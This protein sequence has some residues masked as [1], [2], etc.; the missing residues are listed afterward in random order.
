MSHPDRVASTTGRLARVGFTDADAAAGRLVALEL[1]DH[2]GVVEE[3]GQVADPD[4]A[5]IALERIAAAG[6]R[7]ELL[8]MVSAHD[9]FRRRLLA[10]LGASAALGDWLVRHPQ[11]WRQ[12][13]DDDAAAARPT[14]FGLQAA[15]KREVDGRT[16]REAYDALRVGYRKALLGLAARDLCADLAVDN[17]AAELADLAEATL[18]AALRIAEREH[19]SGDSRLAV[20]AMGKCG[21]RELNYVSD[22]DVVFVA[23][24]ADAAPVATT[25]AAAMMRVCSET[26]SEGTI[27][28]VDAALRP[29][30]KSG[31]LVRTLA[32]HVGYYER[33]ASTWEFQALLKARAVAG[34]STLGAEYV[35]AVAP[36]VWDA[37]G[38]PSFVEDVQAMRRRVVGTLSADEAPRQVKLGP[39]GL[40]DVEF[41]VQLL[42]LVHGRGDEALRSPTTLVALDALAAGG[43]VGRDDAAS[44]AAAY[45]FLRTVEHRL[46]LQQLRRT[47]LL[48]AETAGMR[49]L[50][51]SMGHRDIAAWH[52]EY[53]AHVREVRRIHE[54]LFYRPL[55]NAVARLPS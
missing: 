15:L 20:I 24:P 42:Q 38:R 37:A 3:F 34:D 48:P 21:G 47:H 2:D 28:P 46:Q 32:S 44:L 5:L 14:R 49:W 1:A 27:W 25:V 55:L 30:G 51:R 54:K 12:L 33:W 35:A 40:R 4:L 19:P 18:G 16:G 31:P 17:V 22:V 36:M 45:R 10:V 7:D 39:G 43:Y 13:T 53:D 9:G 11:E 52:D 23:E 41:A 29:E 8:T 6:S 26:T 50:A